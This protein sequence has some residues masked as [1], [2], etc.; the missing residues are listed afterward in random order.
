MTTI[1]EQPLSSPM[2]WRADTLLENDG[3]VM[4][5][6]GCLDEVART[7]AAL[8]ANPLPI[9]A[10]VTDDFEMPACRAAMARVRDQIY[11][12]IGFAVIDRLPVEQLEKDIS[13]KLYWLLMSM[14]SRPVAQSWKGTMVYDVLDTGKKSL[15]GS[16][17]RSSK[18]N[19]G[20]SYHCD[21]TFNL[22]PDFV[23]LMCLQT[24][25]KGGMSGLISLETV[26]NLLLE[27]FPD[28]I[29]R[30]YEP[31]YFD[32]QMEHAPDDQRC[33][34]KPVFESDGRRLFANFNPRRVE[35]GYELAGKEMEPDTR[36][37]IQAL[38]QVSE[39][40]GLGKSF[41]FERGQIQIVNNKRMAHRRTAF[42]DWPEP[43]RRRHLVR[44]WLRDTGR[45]FYLG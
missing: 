1:R 39:R 8:G 37:A 31:F 40:S 38:Q 44:I 27:E 17:V 42:R 5:D 32:R 25:R 10:L 11:D 22:P 18:T 9:E 36:E 43:D 28:V 24:A 3:L 20:Q 34:Y 35:H 23:G 29:P 45:P 19:G 26:Y 7:A 16:G 4:L 13:K 2:T 14:I 41:E 15:A 12:G 6:D 30:L 33:S 21:N